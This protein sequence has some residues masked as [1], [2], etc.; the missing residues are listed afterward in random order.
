[1]HLR[2]PL[3]RF[4]VRVLAWLPLTFAVWYFAAPVLLWPAAWL[5]RAVAFASFSELVRSIEQTRAI[6]VFG[7]TLHPGIVGTAA[8]AITVEV[9]ALLYAFG[10]PLFAAL[11]LAAAEPR[12][13][14]VLAIGY[15][16]LLPVV[17]WG[18]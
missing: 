12:R 14:R 15:G 11:A 13:L 18:A 5:T 1:M 2:S 17:T 9:N 10:M 6:F 3:S 16:A 7:T 8:A 4:V